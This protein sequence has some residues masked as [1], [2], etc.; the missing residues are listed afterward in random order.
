M[1]NYFQKL[2]SA[3]KLAHA[4][5]LVGSS[6]EL[7]LWITQS[8][9]CKEQNACGQ[10]ANCRRIEHGNHPDVHIVVPDGT[11][12]KVDQIRELQREAALKAV[13]GQK[14]VFIIDKASKMNENAANA[15]LKS[16][17]EPLQDTLY[18]L[19]SET[20]NNILP[21]IISR[22][23]TLKIK[24][25]N[26]LVSEAEK[27][28]LQ[29]KYLNIYED[30]NLSI[31]QVEQYKDSIDEW[32]DVISSTLSQNTSNAL[33]SVQ[34]SWDK[35]FNDKESKQL[36]TVLMQSYVRSAVLIKRGKPSIWEIDVPY[37]WEQLVQLEKGVNNIQRAIHSNGH[38][39]LAMEDF[40]IQKI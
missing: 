23:Q 12:I 26:R 20:K 17:E 6:L 40:F 4:Y 3:N 34:T 14:Q 33:L 5:L 1:K 16:L 39:L 29:L 10:C 18:L 11:K 9:Y 22:V 24:E 21:T 19:V 38:F 27:T 36:A 25:E 13:E 30:C 37:S 7:A 32:V 2:I 28:N 31:E 8:V 15:L 35:N